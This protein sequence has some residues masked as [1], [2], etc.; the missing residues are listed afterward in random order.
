MKL[1]KIVFIIVIT[2]IMLV[3]YLIGLWSIAEDR[4]F[5]GFLV[6]PTDGNS[7]L[8][9]MQ[10]GLGGDWRFKLPYTAESGEG[11]YLFLFYIFLGHLCRWTGLAP[12]TIYH[13]ARLLSGVVLFYVLDVFFQEIF[14]KESPESANKS[15]YLASIGAG[16]GWLASFAGVL[17]SDLW[18]PE[19]YPFF[20]AYATPHFPL[21]MALLL[22]IFT[23]SLREMSWRQYVVLAISG[24]FLAVI[25]PFGVVTAGMVL[26]IQLIWKLI[27]SHKIFWQ[28]V[29]S[30][31]ALGGPLLLYQY[32]A[33]VTDPILAGWNTQNVTT[34]PE[35]WE[36]VIGFLPAL[37]LVF[38]GMRDYRQLF[39][40]EATRL[41]I[42]WMLI[43]LGLIYF[44]FSLQRRF[45][46]ALFVPVSGLAVQGLMS[47]AFNKKQR[48]GMWNA[49]LILSVPTNII[50]LLS[51]LYGIQTQ[52]LKLY[53][54]RD[55]KA[56]LEWIGENTSKD[57]LI[58]SS[59]EMGLFIPAQTG[60]RVLYG[61]PFETV[62]ADQEKDLVESFYSEASNVFLGDVLKERG[63]DFIFYG[64]R[65][66]ALGYPRV[67][68]NLTVAFSRGEVV[69]FA[70][71]DY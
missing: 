6:N 53:L 63:I 33:T 24:A 11:A 12:I 57:A 3:P 34:A 7:Y 62:D 8:A 5:V 16:L 37:L 26:G 25:M 69:L 22:A 2:G 27:E 43:S 36:L 45:M 60:R 67:L 48:E 19:A 52:D 9:K 50:L 65:E 61:H 14:G 68:Q 47:S 32:W 39:K 70:V 58:L 29:F 31:L 71:G 40:N 44:P 49:L 18:I 10:L 66:T 15:F 28:P 23:V 46:F 42:I 38:W 35:I 20:S 4:V 1:R 51:G 64:P 17:S 55:E 59:P 13:L 30:A 56:V 41:L 21:G 54:T